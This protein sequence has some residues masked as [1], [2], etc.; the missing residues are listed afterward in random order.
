MSSE[1]VE[2]VR[3][4]IEAWNQH[5]AD[6][7]LSYAAPDVEWMPAGPAAVERTVYRGR[8]EVASGFAAVWQTWDLFQFEEDQ[9]RD[10]GDSVLWLGRVKMRGGASH[11][12]LDQ[13]FAVHSRL[14]DGQVITVRAFLG[15]REALEAV[16]LRE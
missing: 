5:D 12:D 16:G 13:E 11:L 7:W 6:L 15:W 10:L 14:Q 9:V 1:N 2:I 8:D 4:G 3:K